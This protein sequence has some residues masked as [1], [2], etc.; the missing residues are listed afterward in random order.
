MSKLVNVYDLQ[1]GMHACFVYETEAQHRAVMTAFL[2]DGLKKG[3]QVYYIADSHSK[4]LVV[5][6]LFGEAE[7]S[8]ALARGQLVTLDARE[9]Y[10]EDGQFDAE[11][12]LTNAQ[13]FAAQ[14]VLNGYPAM[15]VTGEMT[16]ALKRV[17]GSEQLFTYEAGLNRDF[18]PTAIGICQY[19]RNRFPVHAI[20]SITHTH[21]SWL[22]THV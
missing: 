14:S 5:D 6:Y 3:E 7:L 8:Q 10:L 15:R 4:S 13:G 18:P 11:R 1:P 2:L 21:P 16:W 20:D 17:P 12:M 22:Q 19:P 9:T